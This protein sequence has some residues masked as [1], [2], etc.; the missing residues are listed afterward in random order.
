MTPTAPCAP[1]CASPTRST[2]SRR[3]RAAPVAQRQVARRL[4]PRV[5]VA[6]ERAERLVIEAL[7]VGCCMLAQ[8]QVPEPAA[9]LVAA[10]PDLHD[11]GLCHACVCVCVC[12]SCTVCYLLLLLLLLILGM[13]DAGLGTLT[14]AHTASGGSVL[15]AGKTVAV[16]A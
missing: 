9:N 16:V 8:G 4:G 12:V 11:N 14:H 5:H 13:L 1:W 3:H 10:L 15:C 7:P 6:E 2:G